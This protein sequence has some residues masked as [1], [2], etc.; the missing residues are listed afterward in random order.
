MNDWQ[1]IE[2]APKTGERIL[3]SGGE[4]INTAQTHILSSPLLGVHI[5]SFDKWIAFV[6]P[7]T[8]WL[9]GNAEEYREHILAAPRWWQPLPRSPEECDE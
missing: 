2:T 3:I 7:K 4:I 9:I 5:A 8:P 1:P 6:E